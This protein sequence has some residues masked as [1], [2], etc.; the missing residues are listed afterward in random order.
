MER[1]E[2]W[3]LS[4]LEWQPPSRGNPHSKEIWASAANQ[5]Y[6]DYKLYKGVDF[7]QESGK[8]GKIDIWRLV[9]WACADMASK[10]LEQDD[11]AEAAR[12]LHE[13]YE[14]QLVS[15]IRT[16][17]RNPQAVLMPDNPVPD[18]NRALPLVEK[19]ILSGS[20]NTFIWFSDLAM[21]LDELS[22]RRICKSLR[23]ENMASLAVL[24]P[25]PRHALNFNLRRGELMRN[26]NRTRLG[27]DFEVIEIP[28]SRQNTSGAGILRHGSG[29]RNDK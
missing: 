25:M 19:A 2:K 7:L 6:R 18:L 17:C 23:V 14:K 26:L 15:L 20:H 13:P 1:I 24:M 11:A 8:P 10:A 21:P 27:T 16:R 4:T 22:I 5:L 9:Q 28:E 29:M 12:I 3:L